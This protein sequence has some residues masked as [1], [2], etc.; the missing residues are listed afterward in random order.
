MSETAIGIHVDQTM[1]LGLKP[2]Q[3]ATPALELGDFLTGIIPQYPKNADYIKGVPYSLYNNDRYG[4]CGPTSVANYRRCVTSFLTGSMV[5]PSQDDVYD[6]YRR[7]GNPNFDPNSG[8]D[9]NGVVMQTMLQA[10]MSGGIG[11][12]KC[13]G[14]ARVNPSKL[15]E[16]DAAIAIF[17]GVLFGVNL[18]SA[19]QSQTD[20]GV[21]DYVPSGQWGGHAV[22]GAAFDEGGGN[23]VITWAKRVEMTDV[24]I[25]RQVMEAWVVIW[26]EHL[27][28]KQFYQGLDVWKL[29]E[30]YE[31]ITSKKF[32]AVLPPKPAPTPVPP[33]STGWTITIVG[34]GPM[35]SIA[36]VQHQPTVE[37]TP[38]DDDI[39]LPPIQ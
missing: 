31:A 11:G 29:S 38:T 25:R 20:N 1:K 33:T 16:L 35:P 39:V 24:F 18:Q 13:V 10:L 2:A 7:S 6:L 30:A 28:T 12:T 15:D 17:G 34:S 23:D 19:Q 5:A 8:A 21:W 14:Y 37:E 3:P 22:F 4:V 36:K 27:K 32:P 26:P 9:D